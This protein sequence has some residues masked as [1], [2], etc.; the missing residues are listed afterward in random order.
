MHFARGARRSEEWGAMS[1]RRFT[2][3]FRRRWLTIVGELVVSL[4]LAELSLHL[5]APLLPP[6]LPFTYD[7]GVLDS[8]AMHQAPFDFDARLGWILRPGADPWWF[9]AWARHNGAGMRADHEYALTPALGDWVTGAGCKRSRMA[10]EVEQAWPSVP[11][12]L[13]ESGEVSRGDPVASQAPTTGAGSGQTHSSL[14]RLWA[15]QAS[16]YSPVTSGRPRKLTA[17][18]PRACFSCPNTGSTIVLRRA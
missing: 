4:C 14:P 2:G 16:R 6:R 8:I 12:A 3:Y 17:A 7:R 18:K 9:G 5:A 15:R 13:G 10:G 11:W 1:V